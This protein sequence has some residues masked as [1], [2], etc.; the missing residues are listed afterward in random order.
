MNR[1]IR[2]H[3]LKD[4]TIII[5]GTFNFLSLLGSF[6]LVALLLVATI[7]L[8][9][10]ED[11]YLIFYGIAFILFVIQTFRAISKVI[12]LYSQSI[13]VTNKRVMGKR[14]FL[15]IVTF[16]HPLEKIDSIAISGTFFGK[17]FKFYKLEIR[18]QGERSIFFSGLSNAEAI[19]DSFYKA[20]DD[21]KS[22]IQSA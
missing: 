22:T 6:L 19:R 13:V 15:S 5:A 17:I 20:M 10:L 7:L 21:K 1:Y 16:E 4:E 3:L 8:Y 18:G 2:K 12:R 14:G 9:G 11:D